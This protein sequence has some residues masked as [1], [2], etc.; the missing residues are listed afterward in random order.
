MGEKK[1]RTCEPTKLRGFTDSRNRIA[2]TDIFHS[3]TLAASRSMISPWR[4]VRGI[5]PGL[6]I[7]KACLNQPTESV[8]TAE[9]RTVNHLVRSETG[10]PWSQQCEELLPFF[11]LRLREPIGRLP[12]LGKDR[13]R[14]GRRLGRPKGRSESGDR[15]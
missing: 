13:L 11:L 15:W 5:D 2:G 8:S 6:L 3:T 9:A 4:G 10:F 7:S 1:T 14:P 12:A